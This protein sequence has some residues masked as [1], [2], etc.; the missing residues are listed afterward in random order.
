MI[1]KLKVYHFSFFKIEEDG[2]LL[3]RSE[4]RKVL[5]WNNEYLEMDTID[6]GTT[7]VIIKPVEVQKGVYALSVQNQKKQ[8]YI[9]FDGYVLHNYYISLKVVDFIE[10]AAMWR[11]E[12]VTH[13]DKVV[14]K[15][16][17]RTAL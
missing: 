1:I 5:F 3:T 10:D 7:P 14:F 4:D 17:Y 9:C 15:N 11:I 6:K 8:Q 2:Y 16:N 13:K 12:Q